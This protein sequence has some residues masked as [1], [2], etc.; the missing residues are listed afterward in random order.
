MKEP[1]VILT[2]NNDATSESNSKGDTTRQN[3]NSTDDLILYYF[4]TSFSSQKVLIS[5]FEKQVKFKPC[6]VSLFHGQHMEP[7][8]I[9]LNPNGV[10]VPVLVHGDK[11]INDPDRIIEY[12]DALKATDGPILVPHKTS[13]IGQQV[14][15]FQ[16]GLEKIHVDVIS[17]GIIF[18]PHLSEGGC[19]LPAAIQ[20]SMKENFAKRLRYLISLS[21]IYPD[22]RDCYLA[23]SQTAAEKYDL[24]TDEDRVKGHIEQLSNFLN[25]VEGEL[26]Q[27][28]AIDSQLPDTMYLFGDSL[29]IADIGLYVLITRLQLLGLLPHC[30]PSS[31]FP[32]THRHYTLLSARPSINLLLQDVSKL[33]YTLLLEDLKASGTYAALALGAGLVLMAAYYLIKKLKT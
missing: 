14:S 12:A 4:P 18:H 19:Q 23:K 31:K 8:Y 25:N 5:F 30:V 16:E 22:L 26:R 29:T 20:R 13:L 17:Y 21:T 6:I 9:R 33:R 10:H 3:E 11:V 27:R 24:I 28:Y 2:S 7:W 32:L 15:K 1:N